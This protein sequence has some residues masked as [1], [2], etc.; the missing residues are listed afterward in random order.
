MSVEAEAEPGAARLREVT[1][2]P[3]GPDAAES[4]VGMLAAARPGSGHLPTAV[5]VRVTVSRPRWQDRLR[6]AVVV[7]DLVA[8]NLSVALHRLWGASP[9]YLHARVVLGLGIL[10]LGAAALGT[11]RAWDSRV[12]GQGSEE[13]TRLL[14]AFAGLGVLTGLLGLAL[15]APELRPYAFGVVPIAFVLAACG[16]FLVRKQLHRMRRQGRCMRNVLAVGTEEAVA[17]L[18]TRTRRSPH[19][20]WAITGICLP[21]G[22]TTNSRPTVL[23]VPVIGD[24]DTVVEVVHRFGYHVVSVAP[25]PGWT[26][27]RL[28]LL[29]WDLE[30]TGTEIVVDP[31]LMEIAG[32]RLQVDAVDGFPILRLIEPSF[33]GGARLIKTVSDIVGAAVLLALSAPLMIVIVIAIRCGDGGPAFYRQHRVG[34]S[35]STFSMLKFRSMVV[36]ADRTRPELAGVDRGAGPLFKVHDDPRITR[37]GRFLRRYS[38]DELPQL[39]NVLS[40]SMSLVGPRPPLATEADMFDRDA[41]RRLL[42]KPGMTGLWQVSGRSDLSWEECVRLDL[43]YVENWSLFLDA[44]VIWKTVGAVVRGSGAY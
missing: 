11:A 4:R 31:G 17:N 39:F 18:I 7:A 1:N 26:S 36:D 15:Q 10:V 8:L 2:A 32:P 24:L 14:R 23:D 12:L 6:Q 43:R 40:G 5:D 19:N 42:V 30:G 3:C 25:A 29:A 20:G 35:G 13:F 38:L 33:T 34:K 41:R 9:P 16:R 22:V 21:R 44:L 37:T 27:R 28:H